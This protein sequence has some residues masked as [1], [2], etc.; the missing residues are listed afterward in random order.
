MTQ[1]RL[2]VAGGVFGP[3]TPVKVASG[4]AAVQAVYPAD[5]LV[6]MGFSATEDAGTAAAAEVILRHGKDTSGDEL[7]GVT[8]AAN[9]STSDW[10]A[11]CGIGCPNGLYVDRVSGTTKLTLFVRTVPA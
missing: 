3:A 11:P 10:F 5:D 2:I 4:A 7:F 6:L 8:L 9:E 1:K